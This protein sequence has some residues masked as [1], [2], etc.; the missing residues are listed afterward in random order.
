M[1]KSVKEQIEYLSGFALSRRVSMFRRRLAERTRYLTVCLENIYQ[2][3]NAS[4]V[5]RTCDAFGI[6]DVHILENINAYNINPDVSLGS[7]KWLTLQ[8]YSVTPT[9]ALEQLRA[10]GYRLIATCPSEKGLSLDE[11]DVSAGKCALIFGSE[12]TGL[13]DEAL[14]CADEF[15]YIPMRGFVESLNISVSAAIIL[16]AL[17]SN[18]RAHKVCWQLSEDESEELMLQWLKLSVKSSKRLL[19]C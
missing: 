10:K 6:Q 2:S 7:E 19:D 14:S 9:V 5:L 12:L 18:L 11:F 16:H 1:E 13:S 17:S 15:L 8:R 3:Q 4:A